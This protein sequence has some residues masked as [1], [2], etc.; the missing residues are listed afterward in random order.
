MS[1]EAGGDFSIAALNGKDFGNSKATR[2][3]FGFKYS[4]HLEAST[5]VF[6]RAVTIGSE[7]EFGER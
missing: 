1:D 6:G 7:Q 4:A 3:P 2:L 5:W